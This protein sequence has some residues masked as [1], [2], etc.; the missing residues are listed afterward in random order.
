MIQLK[1]GAWQPAIEELDNQGLVIA[2]NVVPASAGSY[3]PLRTA[4]LLASTSMVGR[5]SGAITGEDST[6]N[7][8]VIAGSDAEL[9]R[10]DATTKAWVP[11]SRPAG[12]SANTDN[13]WSFVEFGSLILATNLADPPQ[14]LD[15]NAPNAR[16]TDLTGLVRGR[17]IATGRGFVFLADTLDAIDG[18]VRYRLRWSALENPFDWVPSVQTQSDWQ[19]FPEGGSITG[20]VGGEAV[21]VFQNRRITKAS[22]IGSPLVWQF[23]PIYQD[24]GCAHPN[25]LITVGVQTFFLSHDGFYM[26][27]GDRV[28]SV[29]DMINET[30]FADADPA[31]LKRMS[32][33]ADPAAKLIHWN[34]ASTNAVDQTPDRFLI[35]NYLTGQWT[36]GDSGDASFIFTATSLPTTIEMLDEFGTIEDIPA[37]FDSSQWAGGSDY[38]AGLSTTGA[39]YTFTGP[40]ARATI[41]TGEYALAGVMAASDQSVTGDRAAVMGIRPLVLGDATVTTSV[42]TRSRTSENVHWSTATTTGATG[43]CPHRSE[44]RYHRVRMTIEG[45]WERA[46]GIDVDAKPSGSR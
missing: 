42:G 22:Y 12:Y 43:I 16:F 24:R 25:S 15:L 39:V 46:V 17:H 32:V 28:T 21:Y 41:E 35:L 40:P 18:A 6:K 27:D 30:F 36:I 23:D 7:S 38:L 34:Y 26:L 19:D 29:G 13:R 33:A 4:A 37:P 3:R 44:G 9:Y 10:Q 45:E 2:R 1:F 14:Y 11:V 20:V 5:P 8:A 31:A